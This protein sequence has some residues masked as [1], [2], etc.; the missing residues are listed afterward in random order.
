VGFASFY[1]HLIKDFS[2]L[3]KSLTDTTSEQFKGKNLQWSDLCEKVLEAL[4][5]KF[6]TAPVI[7][8]YNPIL[9]ILVGMDESDF[10][11][12][13]VLSQKGD[14]VQLVAFYSRK[15][16]ATELNYDIY[17]KEML[18]IVSGFKE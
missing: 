8:Y 12:G 18:A 11:R 13:A 4:K 5:Q 6:T 7:W 14:R 15:L 3:A 10:V 2:K 9:P 16:I 17:D 1:H